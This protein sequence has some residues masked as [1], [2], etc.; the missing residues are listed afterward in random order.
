MAEPG[1][2]SV[3]A[4]IGAAAEAARLV[5]RL[6]RRGDSGR[7]TQEERI[8]Q[9]GPA[10]LSR[11]ERQL[12]QWEEFARSLGTSGDA[13]VIRQAVEARAQ[14]VAAQV[15]AR[16]DVLASMAVPGPPGVG[17]QFPPGTEAPPGKTIP[18]E[19]RPRPR[20][21]AEQK[22]TSGPFG[23][24][25]WLFDR[26]PLR[27]QR[28][29]LIV[30]DRLPPE[31][32]ARIRK[33]IQRAASTTKGLIKLWVLKKILEREG[34]PVGDPEPA[35]A[36]A[37]RPRAPGPVPW[38]R[39]PDVPGWP[40]VPFPLPGQTRA[41][42]PQRTPVPVPRPVAQPVPVPVPVPAP[43]PPVPAPSPQTAPPI[44]RP[45]PTPRAPGPVWPGAPRPAPPRPSQASPLANLVRELLRAR[46]RP[47]ARS[48]SPDRTQGLEPQI[49]SALRPLTA[50]EARRVE[51]D[52]VRQRKR[53]RRPRKPR[54]SC[55]RGTYIETSTSRRLTRRT[56]VSCR[57]GKPL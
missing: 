2:V 24:P 39:A 23:I 44:P 30:W 5:R 35:P 9:A 13:S 16:R 48:R 29:I 1:S 54:T 53:D 51:C 41:P 7:P 50:V 6:F 18:P 36:P 55:W 33:A 38:P 22:M 15:A 37:P 19:D 49:A 4:V 17:V 11:Y 31:A 32:Q 52:P 28:V 40:G 34:V 26:I 56:R 20:T 21:K 12:E 10:E 27:Y 57:T 45:A 25:K 42:A 8:A 46:S 47:R 43:A 3:G 14:R